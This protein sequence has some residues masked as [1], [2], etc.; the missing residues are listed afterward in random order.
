M[1]F[2]HLRAIA[3]ISNSGS[4]TGAAKQLKISQSSL[5]HA[6]TDLEQE[7]GVRLFERGRQGATATEA[8][9]RVLTHAR[10]VLSS[11]DSI[12]READNTSGLLSG[13][14][15][16]GSI[17]SATVAFLPKI[18]GSF[19]RQYPNVEMTLLE[20]PSQEQEQLREWLQE[21][22]IDVALIQLPMAGVPVLPLMRDELCVIVA[23]PSFL[24]R[25]KD[26]SVRELAQ[27]SFVMSRYSSESLIHAAYARARLS[28]VPRFEVQDLGTLVSMIREGLGISIVPRLVFSE[29][30]KGV[31]QIPLRPRICRE[32]GLVVNSPDHSPPAVRAFVRTAQ[33]LARTKRKWRTG[34]V[35][36]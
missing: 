28:L 22:T 6:V 15:R 30:P 36:D 23:A 16:I 10:R 26:L 35:S 31:A 8:G 25:S 4:F 19:S 14:V 11:V 34:L 7:L 33:E 5:S 27:E 29:T 1:K 21:S 9:D 3:A 20:E 17:P 24:A 32:L 13:R 2:H 12:R 18:I